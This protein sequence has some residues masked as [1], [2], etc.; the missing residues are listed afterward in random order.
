[1]GSY[2]TDLHAQCEQN[3]RAAFVATG[4]I[5]LAVAIAV[6][7]SILFPSIEGKAHPIT[8]R[9]ANICLAAIALLGG[10]FLLAATELVR[11]RIW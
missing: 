2:L 10:W 1:M 5:A 3:V 11:S 7:T 6:V 9:V 8:Y 4:A